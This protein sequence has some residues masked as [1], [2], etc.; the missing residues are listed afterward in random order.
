MQRPEEKKH[1]STL[2][3]QEFLYHGLGLAVFGDEQV[4]GTRSSSPRTRLFLT[5]TPRLRQRIGLPG[6]R[7]GGAGMEACI[8][9][10]GCKGY[11]SAGSRPRRMASSPATSWVWLGGRE[12]F[13]SRLSFS[14]SLLAS[15]QITPFSYQI[16]FSPFLVCFYST[17]NCWVVGG[18]VQ[19]EAK[20]AKGC[21]GNGTVGCCFIP[22]LFLYFQWGLGCLLAAV[23]GFRKGLPRQKYRQRGQLLMVQSETQ[24]LISEP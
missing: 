2:D 10:G 17:K 5:A 24:T 12:V 3:P 9:K 11:I 15:S 18:G 1:P 22:T 23:G 21:W 7:H 16:V 19:W 20:G 6:R 14:A 8:A 13:F 4:T